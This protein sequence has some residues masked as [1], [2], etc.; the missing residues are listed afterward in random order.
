[1]AIA[2]VWIEEG[3]ICCNACVNTEAAVFSIPDGMDSAAIRGEVRKDGV[4]DRNTAAGSDL[5]T[6]GIAWSDAIE[7]AAAGCPIEIIRFTTA[8]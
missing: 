3:C 2:R 4:T 6:A 1:M 5:N 7:E 8:A